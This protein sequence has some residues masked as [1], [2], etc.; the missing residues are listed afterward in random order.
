MHVPRSP[1]VSSAAEIEIGPTP[2]GAISGVVF[3]PAMTGCST[4]I[5]NICTIYLGDIPIRL[6]Q[7]V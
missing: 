6:A 7:K 2:T 4:M 1:L 5:A 3:S